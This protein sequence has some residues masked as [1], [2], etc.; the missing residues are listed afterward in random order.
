MPPTKS[1]KKPSTER[2]AASALVLFAQN[3]EE[4]RRW[5]RRASDAGREMGHIVLNEMILA[6]VSHA[7]SLALE[8]KRW[9][10]PKE[11]P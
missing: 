5:Y 9:E 4:I 10:A 7:L 3:L 11:S 1:P 8:G 2:E 6:N